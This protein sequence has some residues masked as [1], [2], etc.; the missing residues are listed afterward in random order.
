M[1]PGALPRRRFAGFRFVAATREFCP[2]DLDRFPQTRK[3]PR[4]GAGFFYV[5]QLTPR[6]AALSFR[7]GAAHVGAGSGIDLDGFALL[8]EE[9]D[10]YCFASFQ[11]R[12]LCHVTRGVATDAFGRLDHFQTD[13]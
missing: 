12:R 7:S 4:W 6:E 1:R 2:A 10:I 8:D 5:N 11:F 13:G 9:R 3:G